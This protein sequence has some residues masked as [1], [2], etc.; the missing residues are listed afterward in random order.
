MNPLPI[1]AQEVEQ[2]RQETTGTRHCVHFN[3]AGAALIP[4]PVRDAMIDYLQHE[5]RHGGYETAAVF[6]DQLAHV[7]PAI[8]RLIGAAP[9]EIAVVE[10]ATVAWQMAFHSLRFAPGD[11][12]LT[13]EVAYLSNYL[14][15]LQA[16]QRYG[17]RIVVAPSDEW[18]QVSV[19]EMAARIS[20]R[21]RLI[22]L[23]HVPTNGGLI[24]PA[25]AVGKLAQAHDIPYLLDA[26]QSAGQLHLDVEAIGCDFLSATGRKYLRAPR[27]TGFLYVRTA[28]L[29]KIE[30]PFIDMHAATLL[31]PDR[32]AWQPGARRFENWESN[33]AAKLGLARAVD[34]ALTIGTER[35][36]QRIKALAQSLRSKLT[37]IPGVAVHDLGKETCGI[38]SITKAGKAAP[39]LREAL[40]AHHIN[41]SIIQPEGALLDTRRRGLGQMLR[42]SV[43]YYN[44]ETELDLLCERI[45]NL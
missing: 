22:A 44:T 31:A 7:Y 10:N 15:F 34:Y 1:S 38:V 9:E 5:S 27:G 42:A 35:I 14:N 20:P 43:H 11:E 4:D 2:Y 3:N 30:P 21:T 40:L 13:T 29:G 39:A 32:Y 28:M 24:N 17:I 18:G 37:A 45:E 33:Q 25:A 36:E 23:T 19:A 16:Q 12:I 8:A 6:Q 41:T 26:C